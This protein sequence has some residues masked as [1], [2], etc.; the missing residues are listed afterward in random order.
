MKPI[1][2]RV[3]NIDELVKAFHYA[4]GLF[5]VAKYGILVTISLKKQKRSIEQN[6]YLWGVVYAMLADEMGLTKD[7]V[8]QMMAIMF[9]KIKEIEVCGVMYAITKST[10][11][12]K[13]DG[14]EEYLEKIRRFA[15]MELHI[16]IPL[17]NETIEEIE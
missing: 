16:L 13:T 17:P 7:E 1:T 11:K 4:K 10:T 12:L 3:F 2:Y 14:M 9:L 6:G 5:E 8:H 15:S